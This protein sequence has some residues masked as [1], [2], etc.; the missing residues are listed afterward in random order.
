MKCQVMCLGQ[1]CV[2]EAAEFKKGK[3]DRKKNKIFSMLRKSNKI[4]RVVK[5]AVCHFYRFLED[6]TDLLC[7]LGSV[8]E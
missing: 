7:F 2:P 8:S 4:G 6:G 3:E 1:H 5:S